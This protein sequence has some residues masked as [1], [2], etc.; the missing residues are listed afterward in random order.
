M[1]Q[2]HEKIV[3]LSNPLS[4]VRCKKIVRPQNLSKKGAN[5]LQCSKYIESL[6]IKDNFE[7]QILT[8]IQTLAS[9]IW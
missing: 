3:A 4:K 9:Q 1:V 2:I 6:K 8:K 7:V 5:Q